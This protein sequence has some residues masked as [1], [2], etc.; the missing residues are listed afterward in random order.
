MNRK[1]GCAANSNKEDRYP[2]PL[3]LD[4]SAVPRHNDFTR[5]PALCPSRRPPHSP[6][7]PAD[8]PHGGCSRGGRGCDDGGRRG[9]PAA[10]GG[11]GGARRR[12]RLGVPLPRPPAPRPP[13][14]P[15][16]PRRPRPPQQRLRALRPRR[17]T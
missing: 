12:R 10:P 15:R 9:A 13:P 14:R 5:A 16:P 4:P 1:V 7:E 17:R 3:R 8:F 2:R 11:A 6:V